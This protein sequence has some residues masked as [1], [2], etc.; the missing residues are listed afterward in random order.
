[1]AADSLNISVHL[2]AP[3]DV[4]FHCPLPC[5]CACI[6]GAYS[7][8]RAPHFTQAPAPSA[9]VQASCL[10]RARP[11]AV[12]A[13]AGGL[14]ASS[15][16]PPGRRRLERK[17]QAKAEGKIKGRGTWPLENLV[18]TWGRLCCREWGCD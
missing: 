3:S 18:C 17:R 15:T 16:A 2:M 7:V 1:M 12:A 4:A 6:A 14:A 10:E 5:H 8:Y 9:Y 11:K 13:F